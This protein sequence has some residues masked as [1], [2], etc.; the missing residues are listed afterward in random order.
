MIDPI[1]VLL[2]F[3]GFAVLMLLRVPIALSLAVSSIAAALWI[4]VPLPLV[5]QKMVQALNSFPLLA[6]PF[7]I[8]AGEVMAG[9]GVA[10]RLRR[11]RTSS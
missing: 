10:R 7:F 11:G 2:L 4:A 1:A 6:I 3:G 8:L 5:G 9:G